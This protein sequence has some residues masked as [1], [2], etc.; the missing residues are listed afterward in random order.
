M[1][2]FITGTSYGIGDGGGLGFNYKAN[3]N[4][5]FGVATHFTYTYAE[6]KELQ[7]RSHL[8]DTKILLVLQRETPYPQF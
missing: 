7:N 2:Y 4:K 8:I 5:Y 1:G 6:Y 3:I